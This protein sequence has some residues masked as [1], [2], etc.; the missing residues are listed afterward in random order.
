MESAGQGTQAN[1]AQSF[2]LLGPLL[3]AAA[4]VG[5]AWWT[6]GAWPDVLVDFGR[7]LYVP[8]R[9]SEGAVLHRD[10]AWFSGPL[11]QH[12]NAFL[13]AWAGVS[14]STLVWA[15]LVFFALFTVL[16]FALLRKLCGELAATVACLVML[17]VFGFAQLVGIGNY[18]F[19]APYSHEI[20]HGLL[21]GLAALA[22]LL[23]WSGRRSPYW[24]VA[25]GA[26]LGLCFLTKAEVFLAAAC[27]CGTALALF[28]RA[29]PRADALGR[30]TRVLFVGASLAPAVITFL[31]FAGD[32]GLV[33]AARVALGAWSQVFSGAAGDLAFY[34]SG[35]GVDAWGLRLTEL[36]AWTGRWALVVV[37]CAL[38]A[39]KLKRGSEAAQACAAGAALAAGGLCA[40]LLGRL[41]WL[42]A[43]RP[44]PLFVLA[45]AAVALRTLRREARE[46][47]PPESLEG[48]RAVLALCVFAFVLLFKMLF[49]ARAQHYGF[50]LA[51]P[52]TLLVVAAL[53]GWLPAFL[54]RR[55][56][57]GMVLRSGML[58]LLAMGT[59][60]HLRITHR[61][62][63]SKT[64]T[65]GAGG[66]AFRADKR[67]IFVNSA[68]EAFARAAEPGDT[69]AVLP[70]GVMLNYLSQ[71]VNSTRYVNFMPPEL[72]FF[73][74]DRILAKFAAAP[75]DW[76]MLVHK[77]TS[78]YGFPLFGPDYGTDL[79]TWVQQ[80]YVPVRQ[81]GQSPL[82][83]GTLFG[84]QLMRRR[85]QTARESSTGG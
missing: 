39:A 69:L 53:V 5:L 18:N 10:I 9:L 48:L 76:V 11:S 37:P 62:L 77:D 6:W 49:N 15:N 31:A 27:G 7:E 1:R 51:L 81:F 50:A 64:E 33:S 14:L 23:H 58:A 44:L 25:S 79:A 22:T 3:I 73:G 71:S 47:A 59:F 66:D 12:V 61:F 26:L 75:P 72:L 45:I 40:V 78:E 13:F 30:R 38:L 17:S 83:P 80:N 34:R 24:V 52:A 55:G 41:D 56:S 46:G 85:P 36:L 65:V 29:A 8:W 4:F 19:I 74:E 54:D 2:G 35:M 20:T 42:S 63:E 43:L 84:I 16:V 82:R 60:A 68:L 28:A 67:G 21:L 57:A 70:E 32:L